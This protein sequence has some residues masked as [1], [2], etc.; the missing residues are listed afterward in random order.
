[1]AASIP[2]LLDFVSL[3]NT[4][5]GLYSIFGPTISVNVSSSKTEDIELDSITVRKKDNGQLVPYKSNGWISVQ[6]PSCTDIVRRVTFLM[7][8]RYVVPAGI[9]IIVKQVVIHYVPIFKY[10]FVASS[11]LFDESR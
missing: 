8:S 11:Y 9:R 2:Y 4:F 3:F 10:Y 1:M 6:F 5:H 7:I